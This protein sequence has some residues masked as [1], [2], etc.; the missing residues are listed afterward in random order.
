MKKIINI[1]GKEYEMKASAYTQ[2]A[3]K[4]LTGR[5]LLEDLK[6]LIVIEIEDE[7]DLSILDDITT[8]VLDMAYV[9]IEEANKEQVKSKED[10]LLNLDS[11]YDD[12]D[13]IKDVI[14]LAVTP[15][16]RRL[17]NEIKQPK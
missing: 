2:F 10:F 15:I 11:L 8:P 13:W 1:D 5:S 3:Y 12:I 4:N 17:Q 14:T 16:S 6:K 7:M 9:M